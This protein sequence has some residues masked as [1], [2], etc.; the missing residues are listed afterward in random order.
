MVFRVQILGDIASIL[1]P[2]TGEAWK[3]IELEEFERSRVG[4]LRG[5]VFRVQ[6]LGDI[7]SVLHP[8]TGKAWEEGEQTGG[9]LT[10]SSF[11]AQMTVV[12][13]IALNLFPYPQL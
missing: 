7:A 4:C 6:I 3:V 8:K 1:H 11:E 2:K 10:G 12:K 5:M 9:Y 13:A